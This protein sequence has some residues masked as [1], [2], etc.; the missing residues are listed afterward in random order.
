[1]NTGVLETYL[2]PSCSWRR[3]QWHPGD[4]C[5]IGLAVVEESAIELSIS[6]D[7]DRLR[8]RGNSMNTGMPETS[9][10]PVC[11]WRQGQ[12]SPSIRFWIGSVLGVEY[13]TGC[14]G[15][16]LLSVRMVEEQFVVSRLRLSAKKQP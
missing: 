2:I 3:T 12:Q 8:R 4:R 16:W 9:L 5:K 7:K 15:I 14:L 6:R 11:S 10:I 13:S 1:M